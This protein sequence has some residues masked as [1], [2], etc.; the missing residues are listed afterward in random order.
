MSNSPSFSVAERAVRLA[1]EGSVLILKRFR[2]PMPT[3]ESSVLDMSQT[4]ALEGGCRVGV[5]E[6]GG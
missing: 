6:Q 2:L 1:L 3:H 4:Q 5:T